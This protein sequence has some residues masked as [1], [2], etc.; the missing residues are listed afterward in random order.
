MSVRVGP[1]VIG[2]F[3]TV[4]KAAEGARALRSLPL[5]DDRITTI[6][7]VALPDGAVARDTRPV[8]FPWAVAACWFAGAA[9]GLGL[10]LLTYLVYPLITAGKPITTVPPTIIVTYEM[11][12][13]GALLGTLVFGFLSIGL[14]RFRVRK[15]F[16]PRIHEG[17]IAVCA[18]VEA[19]GEAARAAA[20][21]SAAGGTE[22]RTE[23]GAL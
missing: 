3:D 5:P 10:T 2:L 6:S 11:A 4:E 1:V 21:L 19:D 8:R 15:V 14:G 18:A 23:E 16:D 20:A 12:M 22:V 13:L 7:S 17:K 9:C